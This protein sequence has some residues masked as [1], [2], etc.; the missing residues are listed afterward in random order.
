MA[1]GEETRQAILARAFEI[2]RMIGLSG[3]SIGRLAE[4]TGLSKSGL[5]AHFGSKE[6]LEVAVVEEAARQF[7]QFV[8]APALRQPRGEPRLRALFDRWIEWG[9]QPGG[10]FFV[11]AT[12]ELDDRPG[13]PRDALVQA[14]RDWL[15]TLA[16]AA[17]IA[18]TE[19]HFHAD[20]D[21]EQFAFEVYSIMLGFH[22]YQKFLRAPATLERA[23]RSLERLLASAR[24]PAPRTR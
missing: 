2:A 6:A 15:D 13:P 7:F 19:G 23:R 14:C 4:D 20:L 22:A 18:V 17:R 12:A 21:P 11:G 5:F 10:C 9:Q 16:T 8:M 1:K 24:A 3:L